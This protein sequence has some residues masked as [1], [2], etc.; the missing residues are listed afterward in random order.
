VRESGEKEC[1]EVDSRWRKG[2]GARMKRTG[3]TREGDREGRRNEGKTEGRKEGRKE[4]R[5]LA[6]PG[7]SEDHEISVNR[8]SE[9]DRAGEVDLTPVKEAIPL[10]TNGRLDKDNVTRDP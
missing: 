8:K 5:W 2:A 10:R 9:E 3:M 7:R 1:T 6:G 4:E